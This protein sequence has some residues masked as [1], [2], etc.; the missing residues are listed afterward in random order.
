MDEERK[1]GK[2]KRRRGRRYRAKEGRGHRWVEVVGGEGGGGGEKDWVRW[3]WKGL[4]M[5]GHRMQR[6]AE[7]SKGEKARAPIMTSPMAQRIKGSRPQR[8]KGSRPN[9]FTGFQTAGA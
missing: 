1:Q 3:G 8:I 9:G 4:L 5:G 2:T 6:K 7:A